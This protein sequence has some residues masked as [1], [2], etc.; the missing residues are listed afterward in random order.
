LP[1][2]VC[3]GPTPRYRDA[4]RVWHGSFASFTD[5]SPRIFSFCMLALPVPLTSSAASSPALWLVTTCTFQTLKGSNPWCIK[6]STNALLCLPRQ[7]LVGLKYQN[8]RLRR[9][10]WQVS[11]ALMKCTKPELAQL[12]HCAIRVRGPVG[13]IFNVCPPFPVQNDSAFTTC[14][15]HGHAD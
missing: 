5:I 7:S 6:G 1:L 2:F 3:P 15:A 11:S 9:R 14:L 8:Q 12:M 4:K 13:P 10:L